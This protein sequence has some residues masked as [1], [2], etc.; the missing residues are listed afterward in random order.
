MRATRMDSS[1]ILCSSTNA[2]SG[3]IRAVRF[4]VTRGRYTCS[5]EP[6]IVAVP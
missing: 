1:V 3:M 5:P 4:A 6:L 2:L